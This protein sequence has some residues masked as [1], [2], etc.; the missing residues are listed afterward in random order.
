MLWEFCL[1]CGLMSNGVRFERQG[2]HSDQN[3]SRSSLADLIQG[4]EKPLEKKE[5][6]GP[7]VGAHFSNQKENDESVSWSPVVTSG[8][9]ISIYPHFL[10]L[11]N[12]NT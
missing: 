12:D 6:G 3:E 9:V 11:I 10:F 8:S 1:C 7:G 2:S 4:K 5:E